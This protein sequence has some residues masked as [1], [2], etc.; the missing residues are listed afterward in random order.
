MSRMFPL[1][2]SGA[3]TTADVSLISSDGTATKANTIYFA[4]QTG[5]A[6]TFC[7]VLDGF[8]DGKSP[9]ADNGRDNYNTSAEPAACG[10]P[11]HIEIPPP[12]SVSS[13]SIRENGGGSTDWY[14]TYGNRLPDHPAAERLHGSAPK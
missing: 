13:V 14:L 10:N 12:F 6:N 2:V 8:T 1:T 3:G 11:I 9:Y 4:P 7:V 5:T